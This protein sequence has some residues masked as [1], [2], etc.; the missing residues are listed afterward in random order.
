MCRRSKA[1]SRTAALNFRKANFVL[2][3]NLLTAIPWDS[4]LEGK[5]VS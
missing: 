5:Q 2:F 3:R 4:A 1:I